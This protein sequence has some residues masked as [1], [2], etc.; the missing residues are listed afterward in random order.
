MI[1]ALV[2]VG[3]NIRNAVGRNSDRYRFHFQENPQ[4][5]FTNTNRNLEVIALYVKLNLR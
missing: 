5:L 2:A 4:C 3:K 1:L